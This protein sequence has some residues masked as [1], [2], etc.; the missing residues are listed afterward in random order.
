MTTAIQR[1]LPIGAEV[2]AGGGVHFRVWA[3]RA[4]HVA[5][6]FEDE[7]VHPLDKEEN[8]YFSGLVEDAGTGLLYQFQLDGKPGR[9][10]D[11]ASRFQPHGPHGPSQTIDPSSFNW[12]DRDW[13]GPA[14]RG[15]VIYE[16]HVGTFT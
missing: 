3:P 9:Y 7:R 13:R 5:V 2:I 8:G 15:Q 14:L 4:E 1:Q 10:P 16:L 6:V 12:T 11:P